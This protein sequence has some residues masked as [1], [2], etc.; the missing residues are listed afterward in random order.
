MKYFP[1]ILLAIALLLT[2]VDLI[3][4]TPKLIQVAVLLTIVSLVSQRMPLQ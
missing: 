3:W 2:I 4:P 1:N